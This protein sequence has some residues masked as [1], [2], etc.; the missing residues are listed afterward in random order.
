M[1]TIFQLKNIAAIIIVAVTLYACANRGQGPQGG[2]KD[3]V[4]PKV[5]KTSPQIK[6]VNVKVNR[7]EIE[8]DEN[9]N[10]KDI[11]KN[12]IISPP[13]RIN[14][15]ITSYGRKV[16]IQFKDTLLTNTTYSIDFGNAIVDNNEGNILKNY[17]YSFA[18]G[19]EID[20]LEI[21]GTLLN[22]EDLNPL[23]G[24]T[25][26][27]YDDL[28][29]TVFIKKPFLRISRTD[30]NGHFT[31]SNVKDGRYRVYA[32][33]DLNRDY[34]LQKG[35]GLAFDEKS[36]QTSFESITRPDTL[37]KD[38][39]TIDTIRFVKG[40]RFLPD[41]VVLRYFK[42]DYKRQYL[43]KSERTEPHLISFFFN[44][45]ADKLPEIRPLN[46]E[47]DNKVLLQKNARLDSLTY[48]LTD[49]VLIKTDTITLEVKY[50]KSD[51][52]FKLQPQTDTIRFSMRKPLKNPT[53][54]TKSKKK[55]LLGIQTNLSSQFGVYK[56]VTLKFA[57]PVKSFD[58]AK[59]HLSQL[60]DTLLTPIPFKL[61]KKDSI[62]MNFEINHK[63]IPETTYQLLID[64]AAFYSIYNLQ[65]DDLKNEMKIRSL[66]E[67]SSLE[68]V[69]ANYDSTAII[70]VVNKDDKL[71]RS[72]PIAK[73]VT[74]V[75]YL[76]PGEYYLRMY[77]DR[78][79]NGKW[80]PGNYFEKRQPEEVYYYE[81]KL[82]LIKNWKF[83]ETWDHTAT[84]LL[85]QKPQD[86]KK[87]NQQKQD[88]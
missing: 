18:T 63:W 51:S 49:S 56:P 87:S 86:L 82:T 71:V 46:V 25:V 70:Q 61:E 29:D 78:N 11:A 14:P 53:T 30:E 44:T 57:V 39:L 79:G 85:K 76:E 12:V 19:N 58:V 88:N 6:S 10:L 7:I 64:S 52:L 36:F 20:T 33:N 5:M 48:W 47:W 84:P 73:S 83:E 27:I 38:S 62:G 59:I 13:Q 65:S 54:T 67:Y 34:F 77:L 26:G 28:S 24:I 4:P 50:L 32:L 9:V 69:L 31:V 60:V 16:N 42:D 75:E 37:W 45:L 15:E 23:Q 17:V 80:D 43:A 40:T 22:A 2:A 21:A 41:D 3:E 72:L 1:K 81:K 66:D 68:L 55:E 74:K 8:F 35:E